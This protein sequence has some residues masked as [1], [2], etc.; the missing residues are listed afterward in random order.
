MASFYYFI[1]MAALCAI[2]GIGLA[3]RGADVWA[4]WI[5]WTSGA[6]MVAGWVQLYRALRRG[7]L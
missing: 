3:F 1:F 5:F 7:R 4:D 6:C 2:A